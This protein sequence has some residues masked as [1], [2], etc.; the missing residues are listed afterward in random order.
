MYNKNDYD[1]ENDEMRA[2][3]NI[4][5]ITWLVLSIIMAMAIVIKSSENGLIATVLS[6]ITLAVMMMISH[7]HIKT[8]K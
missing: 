4:T 8:K 6:V 7:E 2:I 1:E 3:K 5:F